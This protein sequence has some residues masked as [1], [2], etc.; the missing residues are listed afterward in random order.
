MARKNQRFQLRMTVASYYD[1]TVAAASTDQIANYEI[2]PESSNGFTQGEGLFTEYKIN[3]AFVRWIPSA[4]RASQC[5]NIA[6]AQVQTSNFALS[7]KANFFTYVVSRGLRYHYGHHED[8]FTF[9]VK[10]PE[11]AHMWTSLEIAEDGG[12]PSTDH[13]L[14]G[15]GLFDHDF[16]Q[17]AKVGILAFYWDITFRR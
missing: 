3:R 12:P 17:N 9:E 8:K 5:G 1:I 6:F 7:S 16:A 14:L 15:Y 4:K 2:S 10:I 13:P 11:R